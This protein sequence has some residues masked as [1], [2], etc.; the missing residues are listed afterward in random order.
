MS[1]VSLGHPLFK[2]RLKL[3][4]GRFPIRVRKAAVPRAG[5][6][7]TDAPVQLID[8]QVVKPQD[9]KGSLAAASA[10]RPALA[11]VLDVQEHSWAPVDKGLRFLSTH[12]FKPLP[13][14]GYDTALKSWLAEG[15]FISDP[16]SLFSGETRLLE[17]VFPWS[18][19]G[20]GEEAEVCKPPAL[21]PCSQPQNGKSFCPEK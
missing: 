18:E 11:T 10:Q 13:T 12:C 21:V 3:S 9:V 14:N 20:D 4:P 16:F 5:L 6:L 2:G 7:S 15:A 1:E 19:Q 17:V 8:G